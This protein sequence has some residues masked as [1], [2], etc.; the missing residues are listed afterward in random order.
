MSKA[1]AKNHPAQPFENQPQVRTPLIELV[2]IQRPMSG[3]EHRSNRRNI[4][5]AL[6]ALS[7]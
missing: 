6:Q 3:I 1:V 4:G 5:S 2:R 7:T